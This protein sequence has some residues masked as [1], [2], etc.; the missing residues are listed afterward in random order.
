MIELFVIHIPKTISHHELEF[1]ME[2]NT[3]PVKRRINRCQL[4]D[5]RKRKL[6]GQML[7]RYIILN[8][9]KVTNDNIDFYSNDYGKPYLKGNKNFHFNVSH[10]GDWVICAVNNKPIGVDV[11]QIKQ[12]NIRMFQP[13]FSPEEYKSLS[14]EKKGALRRFYELWTY[15]ESFIKCIGLGLSIP[16]DSFTIRFTDRIQVLNKAGDILSRFHF[17]QYDIDSNYKLAICSQDSEFDRKIETVTYEQI[18]SFFTKIP[19]VRVKL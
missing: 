5:E 16:L 18:Y 15:K 19:L 9:F 7:I 2:Y 14:F 12:I 6:L 3:E 8:K 4:Q 13:F 17:Y 1:L 11:E 10:S